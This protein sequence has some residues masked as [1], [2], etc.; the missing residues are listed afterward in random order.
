M[1]EL[2]KEIKDLEQIRKLKGKRLL[3]GI[4]AS[5]GIAVGIVRNICKQ[6]PQLIA[7]MTKG[8]VIVVK[9]RNFYEYFPT[10][11]LF[12]FIKM[13]GAFV[14]DQGGRTS[15]A[16]IVG[17]ELGIPVVTGTV[18]GTTLLNTGQKVIV[19]GTEGA[20]YSCDQ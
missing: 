1:P 2:S 11:K 18:D 12:D 13:V 8:D 15:H 3:T 14:T 20:V 19:D 9:G 17:R 5:E 7:N 6:D 4:A 16:G 10:E